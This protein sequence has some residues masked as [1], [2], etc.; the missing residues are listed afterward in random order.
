MK[1]IYSAFLFSVCIL[2]ASAQ[3]RN[4]E[5]NNNVSKFK[6]ISHHSQLLKTNVAGCDT[7]NLTASLLDSARFYTVVP[8][9]GGGF[10]VGPNA[11]GDLQKAAYFQAPSTATYLTRVWIAFA[12]A[13]SNVGANLSKSVAIN[14]YAANTSGAPGNLITTV[15]RTLSSIK[16]DVDSGKFTN[17]V[18]PS[19]ISL[20]ADK[21]FFISVDVSNLVWSQTGTMDSLAI[22]SS[23][24]NALQENFW[25][26]WSDNSWKKGSGAWG[27]TFF[28]T[29]LVHPFVSDNQ[30]CATGTVP[31]TL[32]SFN[33]QKANGLNILNWS[34]ST[35][36]NNAGFEIERS[37]DG[38]SFSGIAKVGSKAEGGNSNATLN[39][40][41]VDET[42]PS[43]NNY[44]RLKQVDKDGKFAYSST[45]MIKGDKA[46]KFEL[47]SVYPN[48]VVRE[49]NVK[50]NAASAEKVQIVITD[51]TG[52]T[53]RSESRQL[54]AGENLYNVNVATLQ[55]GTY[56]IRT[57]TADGTTITQKFIKQ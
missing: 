7:L 2:S 14:V 43:G 28:Q 13:N 11:Y 53:I 36:Q 23:P 24:T 40:S 32:V 45:V 54:N 56:I 31:V 10:V 49:L 16:S 57:V 33:G 27:A 8:S 18:F 17:I 6:S 44:Y 48:P 30:T 39:Y 37:A 52:K 50:F 5:L 26:Q 34:T 25:E 9:E 38:K 15:T 21:K 46:T 47:V 19:A 55:A 12:K 35:E 4:Y 20:P 41:F 22:Y 42:A 51:L 29:L 1:K 3:S